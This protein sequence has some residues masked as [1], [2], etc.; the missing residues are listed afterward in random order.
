MGFKLI[1][2]HPEDML[3]VCTVNREKEIEMAR[4]K[5]SGLALGFRLLAD[6]TRLGMVKMLAGGPKN[7]TA[8]CDGLGCK[9]PLISHHLGLLRKGG[10]VIGAR[11]GKSVVYSIDAGNFKELSAAIRKMMPRQ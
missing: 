7:V 3:S 11:K 1:V 8:L 10:L 9:Q 4:S 6:R 2:P 5:V